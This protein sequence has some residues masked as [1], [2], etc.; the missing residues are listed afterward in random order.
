MGILLYI[1]SQVLKY[2]LTLVFGIP[3]ILYYLTTF[4]WWGGLK[5]LN[6]YY[7]HLAFA[8]DQYGNVKF[9]VWMNKFMAENY[10][11]PYYFGDEDDTISY[12]TAMNYYKNRSKGLLSFVGNTLNLVDNNHLHK[13]ITNKIKRDIEAYE[14]LKVSGIIKTKEVITIKKTYYLKYISKVQNEKRN[15]S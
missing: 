13:A 5:A 15:I 2:I 10:P 3:I 9:K 11:N 12:C 14:R 7:Y 6:N 8:Q 1:L 4:K